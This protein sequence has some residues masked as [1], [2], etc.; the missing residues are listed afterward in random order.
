MNIC[1]NLTQKN[2][3]IVR[4][5]TSYLPNPGNIKTSQNVY[6][7]NILIIES[8]NLIDITVITACFNSAAGSSGDMFFSRKILNFQYL[9]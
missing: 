9:L 4:Y 8:D 2:I 6:F 5:F 3:K 1:S 7:T